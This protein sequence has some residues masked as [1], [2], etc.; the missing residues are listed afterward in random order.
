MA[1]PMLKEIMSLCLLKKIV[2]MMGTWDISTKSVR[3]VGNS[4]GVC[5]LNEGRRI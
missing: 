4:K 1:G 5:C 2:S 3:G